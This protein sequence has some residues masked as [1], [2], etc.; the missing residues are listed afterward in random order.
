MTGLINACKHQVRCHS[1][2]A[3]MLPSAGACR[4]RG[5]YSVRLGASPAGS[6]NRSGR[7]L[8]RL[9]PVRRCPAI[10][11]T[12]LPLPLQVAQ[13]SLGLGGVTSFWLR[14]M[15][16]PCQRT[17]LW[18]LDPFPWAITGGLEELELERH[19]GSALEPGSRSSGDLALKASCG[20]LETAEDR[21]AWADGAPWA[22]SPPARVPQPSKC[23]T[24]S[25]TVMQSADLA[26][27]THIL[28]DPQR[29]MECFQTIHQQH[30][31][32]A[33]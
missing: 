18:S 17:R 10:R 33:P 5:R 6:C 1:A 24:S 31:H 23:V 11:A 13:H 7:R 30:H 22:D 2:Y 12:A 8:Q 25:N 4:R 27:F 28:C 21:Y 32:L 20:L 3:D 19:D 15:R 29:V 9:C 16:A 26:S 14:N